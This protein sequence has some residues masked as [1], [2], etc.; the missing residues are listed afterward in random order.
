MSRLLRCLGLIADSAIGTT[1]HTQLYTVKRASASSTLRRKTKTKKRLQRCRDSRREH[2]PLVPSSPQIG[3]SDS[4]AR[5][6]LTLNCYLVNSI[7]GNN[8]PLERST[9]YLLA[10]ENSIGAS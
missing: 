5:L 6:G 3:R 7:T 10:S 2:L 9:Y 1:V 8:R 4:K